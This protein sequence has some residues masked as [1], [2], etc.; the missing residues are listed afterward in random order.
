MTVTDTRIIKSEI[1]VIPKWARVLAAVVFIAVPICFYAFVWTKPSDAPVPFRILV[2]FLP[3]S[4][5]AVLALMVGYVNKDAGRRGMNRTLWTLLVIF[6]PNAIGFILYFLLRS[7]I[8]VE[9]P[10]CGTVVD[11]RVNFCPHCRHSFHD[12]CPQCRSAVRP[13]DKFCANCG[14]HVDQVA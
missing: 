1:M 6:I 12:T 5:L 13:G 10:K 11:P 7:P 14:A 2:S 8:R 4:I 3:G 9:C